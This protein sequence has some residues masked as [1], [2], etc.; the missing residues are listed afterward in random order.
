MASWITVT[1]RLERG[2]KITNQVDNSKFR[3][4]I[5]R[6]CQTL[7]LSVNTRIFSEEEEEK[8]LVSL[9][10]NKDDL[11]CLLDTIILIY[12]QAT[13]NII[14]PQLME[15]TLKDT[16][17]INDEKVQIF[18]NAWITY[19][20]GIIDHFRQISIFPVQVKD[21]DWCLNIQA[22]SSSIKKDVR[23]MSLLQLNLTGEEES[24]LTV[25][26][27]KKELIDLYNNLEK[28]QS[29]LDAFK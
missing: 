27:D 16:F 21:I 8:L 3:L 26:F 29:Q 28:I 23:P 20:K 9:D 22:A 17:K 1:P 4:L 7:Q 15:S 18:L 11:V 10:V 13:C 2:L 24:K 6:I 5:N 19:G 12:K 14:K 25:E